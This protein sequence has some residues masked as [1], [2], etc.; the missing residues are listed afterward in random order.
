MA[1]CGNSAQVRATDFRPSQKGQCSSIHLAGCFGEVLY[2]TL[3]RR[4]ATNS[5]DPSDFHAPRVTG[6]FSP[7]KLI[8]PQTQQN[9]AV[10]SCQNL[11][12]SF[13]AE[14]D[15]LGDQLQRGSSQLPLQVDQRGHTLLDNA[16]ARRQP[17]HCHWPKRWPQCDLESPGTTPLRPRPRTSYRF[18]SLSP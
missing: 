12:S 11:P 8:S 9:R 14:E 17:P 5:L 18:P 10:Q 7:S 13:W 15:W 3:R 2:V 1:S 4:V 16:P 6:A